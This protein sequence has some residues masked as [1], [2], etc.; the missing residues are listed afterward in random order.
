[1]RSVGRYRVYL[2]GVNA[3]GSLSL[4]LQL[5][6]R[7]S[8]KVCEQDLIMLLIKGRHH[9]LSMSLPLATGSQTDC[10]LDLLLLSTLR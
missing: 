9:M 6:V 3:S 10:I 4:G 8:S 1:M 2:I 7:H 5:T